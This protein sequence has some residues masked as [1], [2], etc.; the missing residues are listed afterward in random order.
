MTKLRKTVGWAIGLLVSLIISIMPV[1]AAYI[2]NIN[3]IGADVVATGVGTLNTSSLGGGIL[4]TTAVN[5]FINPSQPG[6]SLHADGAI[7]VQ[8]WGGVV[9]NPGALGSGIFTFA[10]TGTGDVVQVSGTTLV[11]ASTYVSGGALSSTETWNG[12]TLT[13]LG[14]TP[15]TYIF[16]FGTAPNTDTITVNVNAAVAAAPTTVPTLTEY[17]VITLVS[18]VVLGGIWTMYKRIQI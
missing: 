11:L 12:A 6:F 18:L 15:G 4:G 5:G 13:S 17:G 7:P 14:L 9:T 3:Q 2:L 8:I 1:H 10:S 16:S